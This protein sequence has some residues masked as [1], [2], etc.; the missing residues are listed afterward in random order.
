MRR[1]F[2][3]VTI[4]CVCV[5][6][7][8]AVQ[9]RLTAFKDESWFAERMSYVPQSDKL[10]PFLLGYDSVYANYL[11]IRTMLYFGEHYDGDRDFRWL[12]SMVD[13]VTRLNPRFYPAYEFAGL[14]LPRFGQAADAARVILERGVFF[15]GARHYKIPFYLGWLYYSEYRDYATAA[16]YLSLAARRPDAPPHVIGLAATFFQRAGQPRTARQYLVSVYAAAENPVV[17]RIVAEKLAA[18]DAAPRPDNQTA[19]L[20]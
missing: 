12:S 2:M 4:C 19:T 11:W 17:R 10:Q 9:R 6:T 1:L 20:D 5:V 15:L 14:M 18:L 7:L 8:I 13:I 16:E 3:H